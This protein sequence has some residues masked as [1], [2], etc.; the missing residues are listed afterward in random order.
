MGAYATSNNTIY[1]SEALLASSAE[2]IEAASVIETLTPNMKISRALVVIDAGVD[3]REFLV[4]GILPDADVMVLD[5]HCNAIAQIGEV[6]QAGDFGAL[7]IVAHGSEGELWLGNT[8]LNLSNLLNYATALQS[9]R[10]DEISLY[11]CEVA[12]GATGRDFV[13]QLAVVTGARV[14]AA[15]TKVGN[16]ASGGS[17]DLAVQTGAIATPLMIE[18]DVLASY[19]GVL[20]TI[21][22]QNVNAPSTGN[23]YPFGGRIWRRLAPL[24]GIYL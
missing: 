7:Q 16:R 3:D 19:T 5:R 2:Q 12:S 13:R 8:S 18:N 22:V 9:W 1:L 4:K 10:V 24:Y 17:W 6:L 20:A 15:T 14:A 21:T 11:A 23:Y